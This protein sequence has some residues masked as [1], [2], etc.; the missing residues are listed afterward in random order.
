[1]NDYLKEVGK[2]CGIDTPITITYYKG[3]ERIN[4]VYPKWQLLGTHAGRRTFVCFGIAIGISPQVIM[5]WTGHSDYAAMRPYID[6]VDSTKAEAM[7]KFNDI[8]L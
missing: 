6:I 7:N 5:K 2:A 4:E 1:M 3:N 8:K